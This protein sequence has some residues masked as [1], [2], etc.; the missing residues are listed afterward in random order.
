MCNDPKSDRGTFG[1]L[2]FFL[3][4]PHPHSVT[5]AAR[6]VPVGL[7]VPQILASW[8]CGGRAS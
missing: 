6:D 8:V 5:L 2:I 1:E 4:H 3:F 7:T